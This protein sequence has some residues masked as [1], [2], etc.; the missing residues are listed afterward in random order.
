M[1]EAQVPKSVGSIDSIDYY[2]HTRL[3]GSNTLSGSG[4][5]PSL[6]FFGQFQQG[7]LSTGCDLSLGVLPDNAAG[8]LRFVGFQWF[9]AN[10][11][12]ADVISAVRCMS[13]LPWATQFQCVINGVRAMQGPCAMMG[14]PSSVLQGI[15]DVLNLA[16]N[17]A[18][19]SG[20]MSG[21]AQLE[22]PIG[23]GQVI[24]VSTSPR[25]ALP[26]N[27]RPTVAAELLI[28]VHVVIG[29]GQSRALLATK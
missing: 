3:L 11:V 14:A 28:G 26:A 20:P 16:N 18:W 19:A 21:A 13:A 17:S 2:A 27:L 7:G 24:R 9:H 8:V 1:M 25:Y 10:T 12:A 15:S 23:P 22:H 6:D 4:A 29:V 5:A